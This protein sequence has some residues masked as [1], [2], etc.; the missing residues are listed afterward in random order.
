MQ[1]YV[2]RIE[3]SNYQEMLLGRFSTA[4][5]KRAEELANFPG[6]KLV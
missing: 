1:V 6:D 4:D 3:V 2:C 5:V